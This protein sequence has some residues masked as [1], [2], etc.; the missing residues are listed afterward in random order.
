M[1][2]HDAFGLAGCA[3]CVNDRRQFFRPGP[4]S[5][6]IDYVR[7]IRFQLLTELF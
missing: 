2:Q 6:F 7:L 5:N 4:M 1:R 3:G